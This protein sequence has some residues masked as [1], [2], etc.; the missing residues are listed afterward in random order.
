[1]VESPDALT[2]ASLH[3]ANAPN[4]TPKEKVPVIS[5]RAT[6]VAEAERVVGKLL[7]PLAARLMRRGF[8]ADLRLKQI[9]EGN[10]HS[11]PLAAEGRGR[12]E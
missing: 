9:L 6:V 7:D 5:C 4:T 8:R 3:C 1:V 12:P 10:G 11:R 2:A